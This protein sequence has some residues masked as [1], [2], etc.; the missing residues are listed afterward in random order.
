MQQNVY[1]DNGFYWWVG[2]VED[3]DDPLMLGRCRVR[4]VGYH[5]P[6]VTELP[7]EDLPWAHPIATHHISCHVRCR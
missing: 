1:G 4:I 3:R 2:V 7:V 6:I 5:T